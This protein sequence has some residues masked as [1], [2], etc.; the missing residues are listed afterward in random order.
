[1][2][3]TLNFQTFI[4]DPETDE[5]FATFNN[6]EAREIVT[7]TPIDPEQKKLFC[8]VLKSSHTA[9]LKDDGSTITVRFPLSWCCISTFAKDERGNDV[10]TISPADGCKELCEASDVLYRPKD[11]TMSR[12]IAF[13]CKVTSSKSS[14]RS[15]DFGLEEGLYGYND[16]ISDR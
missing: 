1:M 8:Q 15:F 9:K 5:T 13:V 6:V 2:S 16:R 14:V 4:K 11:S 7:A 10:M 12:Q 3:Y